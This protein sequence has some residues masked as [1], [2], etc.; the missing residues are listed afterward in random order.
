MF[1]ICIILYIRNSI[2]VFNGEDE[3]RK[4]NTFCKKCYTLKN[5]NLYMG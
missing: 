1:F 5:I 3:I 4:G 2:V